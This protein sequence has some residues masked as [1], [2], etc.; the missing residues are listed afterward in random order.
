M[1]LICSTLNSSFKGFNK[2]MI[3]DHYLGFGLISSR[4]VT[5]CFIKDTKMLGIQGTLKPSF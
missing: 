5:D 3:I 2:G 4:R 1:P